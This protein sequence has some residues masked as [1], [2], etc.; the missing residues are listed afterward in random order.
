MRKVKHFDR[1][2]LCLQTELDEESELM[3]RLHQTRVAE[4]DLSDSEPEEEEDHLEKVSNYFLL[5]TIF[6]YSKWHA[7]A[8]VEL[9]IFVLFLCY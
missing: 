7:M 4:D 8:N 3:E 2:L 1:S 5:L 9:Y 6:L